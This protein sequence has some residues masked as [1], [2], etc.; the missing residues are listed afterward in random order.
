[1]GQGDGHLLPPRP[2]IA[3]DLDP[4][5]LR[6]VTRVDGEVRQDGTTA[7]MIFDI[8]AL[9]EHL[10]P[11]SRCS[12]ATSFSPGPRPGSDSWTTGSRV[13][14]E[15]EGIGI[16]RIR[17][18]AGT[19]AGLLD[20]V[21]VSKHR[22]GPVRLRVAPSPTGDPHVGTAYMSLFNLAFARQQ[23]GQFLLRIEDTDRARFRADSEQQV[24]TPP[25]ARADLGRGAGRRWSGRA[26][27]ASPSGSTP[28]GRWSR[29]FQPA[30]PGSAGAAR[31]G[32]AGDA[33]SSSAEAPT[34]YDR[35]CH[36]KSEKERRA[37]PGSLPEQPVVRMFIPA[38][39][40]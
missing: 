29:S 2:A 24:S 4:S 32:P 36:G 28:T 1:M 15:I 23:G 25:L 37:L 38:M 19:G 6:L 13:E 31:S 27:P 26:I 7:D 10:W 30:T 22:L 20:F 5:D 3:T 21:P 18:F 9:I 11:P 16:P 40:R 33:R 35:L 12:P 8:P 39:S 17:S 34:G 14:V